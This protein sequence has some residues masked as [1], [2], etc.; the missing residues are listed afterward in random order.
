MD[1]R[2]DSFD[3]LTVTVDEDFLSPYVDG[4]E[5]FGW[6]LDESVP[7]E[8]D[9]GTAT[10]HL[11]RSRHIGNKVE[12]IRLQQHFEACMAEVR[13]LE[14]SKRSVPVTVSLTLGLAGCG[15]VAG[16]ALAAAAT[17][18]ATWLAAL[19]AVPGLLLWAAAY[20]CHGP[21]KRHRIQ[22]VTPLIEAKHD[23]ADEVCEKA[24]QLS[25][26]R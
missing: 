14:A 4:Y 12:L 15:F 11:K 2:V 9:G 3:Y 10:L 8:M 20:F 21:V 5:K 26:E 1:A 23:E 19:L 25:H 7:T 18:S 6:S 22:K 16:A 13:T 24:F 17:P